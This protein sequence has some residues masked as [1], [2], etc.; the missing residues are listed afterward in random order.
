[1]KV[2]TLCWLDF[3]YQFC[4][5]SSDTASHLMYRYFLQARAIF[6]F[7]SFFLPSRLKFCV[8]WN[9]CTI[10]NNWNSI[11]KCSL[12]VCVDNAR[13]HTFYFVQM[14]F[15]AHWW[16]LATVWI[17]SLGYAIKMRAKVCCTRT[18]HYWQCTA[19]TAKSIANNIYPLCMLGVGH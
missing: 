1:M 9:G 13:C 7:L 14:D 16:L 10:A 4:I 6:F 17:D 3:E 19:F 2:V 5:R 18:C 15:I 12:A 8:V 11:W